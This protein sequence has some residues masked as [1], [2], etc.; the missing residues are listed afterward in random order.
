ME[1][2]G[3]VE[4]HEHRSVQVH[5]NGALAQ[6][7]E[8]GVDHHKGMPVNTLSAGRE[9]KAVAHESSKELAK[10]ALESD[11]LYKLAEE[12][13]TICDRDFHLMTEGTDECSVGEMSWSRDDC[14]LA[15]DHLGYDMSEHYMLDTHAQNPLP[16]PKACFVNTSETPNKVSFNPSESSTEGITLIGK[17]ICMRRMYV[18]GTANTDADAACKAAGDGYVPILEYD[19]CYYAMT[20]HKGGGA[21]KLLPFETNDTNYMPENKPKGCFI[22]VSTGKWGFNWI[23]KKGGTVDQSKFED[24]SPICY[25]STANSEVAAGAADAAAGF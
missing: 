6:A 24:C 10:K 11:T 16:Y 3:D 19:A 7:G 20:C 4:I 22:E 2:S 18:N 14:F 15:A 1:S 13:I 23:H 5:G 9:S 25:D 8:A 17:K 21:P 12:E